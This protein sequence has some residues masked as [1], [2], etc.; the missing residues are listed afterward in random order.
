MGLLA[1]FCAFTVWE[2][3]LYTV[4]T[5]MGRGGATI[6]LFTTE[7]M[8]YSRWHALDVKHQIDADTNGEEGSTCGEERSRVGVVQVFCCLTTKNVR[9]SPPAP[10]L[11][12]S[13]ISMTRFE[14][15][16]D[17]SPDFRRQSGCLR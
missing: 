1:I 3:A 8:G 2:I 15:K 9:E 10:P 5:M 7:M 6:L 13:W 11:S 17:S 14:G 12:S 16:L 4:V